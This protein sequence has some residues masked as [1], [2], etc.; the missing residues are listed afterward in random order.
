MTLGAGQ[1]Q[2]RVQVDDDLSQSSASP[3]GQKTKK[4]PRLIFP[5]TVPAHV[6]TVASVVTQ[7]GHFN[8]TLYVITSQVHVLS[9]Y[10]ST[11]ESILAADALL[12]A[13]LF[14]MALTTTVQVRVGLSQTQKALWS[15]QCAEPARLT[16]T[17]ANDSFPSFA[18]KCLASLETQVG[19]VKAA[20]M[21]SNAG[22]TY[23]GSKC[24]KSM[25]NAISFFRSTINEDGS[26][27]IRRIDQ[28]FG[29]TVLSIGYNKLARVVQTCTEASRALNIQASSLVV[30][31]LGALRFA[32]RMEIHK[33]DDITVTMLDKT[34]DGAPGFVNVVIG[35]LAIVEHIRTH[36]DE[37]A[38]RQECSTMVGDIKQLLEDFGD[39]GKYA[40][41]FASAQGNSN[42]NESVDAYKKAFIST[43]LGHSAVELMYDVY[44]GAHDKAIGAHFKEHGWK[45][46]AA[47]GRVQ[48]PGL[49]ELGRQM[50]LQRAVQLEDAPAA[51]G[52]VALRA[53]TNSPS[54]SGLDEDGSDKQDA[55]KAAGEMRRKYVQFSQPNF[56][57]EQGIQAEFEKDNC[58]QDLPCPHRFAPLLHLQRRHRARDAWPSVGSP[59]HMARRYLHSSCEVHVEATRAQRRLGVVRRAEQDLPCEDRSVGQ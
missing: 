58:V 45:S 36:A 47:W 35:R 5:V 12:V 29:R 44:Q 51:V 41:A 46:A 49:K 55:T 9:W 59:S 54:T 39:Y 48:V 21:L 20:L 25:A 50:N 30:F 1:R 52:V 17:I 15:I 14:Q 40:I 34:R 27:M 16:G 31:V 19:D 22:V 53:L 11:Y 6:D 37:L 18:K 26:R 2:S 13:A 56:F 33:P 38:K 10:L 4:L 42:A 32:L 24:N 23:C 28:E 57:T 3:R 7:G 43:K 8:A